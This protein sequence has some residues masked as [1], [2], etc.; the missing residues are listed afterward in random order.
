MLDRRGL[1]VYCIDIVREPRHNDRSL[2]DQLLFCYSPYRRRM[3]DRTR[4]VSPSRGAFRQR[5]SRRWHM[6]GTMRSGAQVQIRPARE[7]DAA[8]FCEA[9]KV[10]AGL[11]ARGRKFERRYQDVKLMALWL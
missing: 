5:W 8:S 11:K 6:I 9:V 10:V 7:S 3:G 2:L 1:L 4:A